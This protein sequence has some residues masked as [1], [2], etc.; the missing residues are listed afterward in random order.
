MVLYAMNKTVNTNKPSGKKYRLNP[1]K[2]VTNLKSIMISTAS[3][4]PL[5]IVTLVTACSPHLIKLSISNSVFISRHFIKE[6][7]FLDIL[8]ENFT[9]HSVL[10]LACTTD[11]KQEEE[12]ER[13]RSKCPAALPADKIVLSLSYYSKMMCHR[14]L[15]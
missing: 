1:Y 9:C 11:K 3:Q 10:S 5:D 6:T 13:E 8:K 15:I 2:T 12:E 7:R 14:M 4:V